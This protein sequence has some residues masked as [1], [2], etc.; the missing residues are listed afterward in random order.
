MPSTL[1]KIG[2]PDPTPSPKNTIFCPLPSLAL[3][4]LLAL[5]SL[6]ASLVFHASI[7]LLASLGL[8]AVLA[9]LS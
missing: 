9:L 5:L 1:K 2:L 6:L 3:L 7:A 8:L 4:I